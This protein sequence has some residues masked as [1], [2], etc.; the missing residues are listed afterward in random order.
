MRPVRAALLADRRPLR[1]AAK[2]RKQVSCRESQGNVTV[3][4]VL[5]GF[6]QFICNICPVTFLLNAQGDFVAGLYT[7]KAY[8]RLTR[9]CFA[10]I[11]RNLTGLSVD[12]VDRAGNIAPSLGRADARNERECDKRNGD[13]L[14]SFLHLL[15]SQPE[16]KLGKYEKVPNERQPLLAAKHD[17][18]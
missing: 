8:A 16:T 2:D 11:Q 17:F 1:A 15:A 9:V 6:H 3:C 10:V 14:H 13:F 18:T 5:A 4:S 12:F 7:G